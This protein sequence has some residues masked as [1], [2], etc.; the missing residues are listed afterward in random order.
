MKFD[1]GPFVERILARNEEE[2]IAIRARAER[3]LQ[4][5]GILAER[6]LQA[7]PDVKAVILFGSLA[8][9]GPKRLEFDIDIALDGGDPYKAM[10]IT[11]DSAF[12]VDVVSLRLLPAHVRE[13]IAAK[14]VLLATRP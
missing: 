1:P 2:R 9:S 4:E 13:R 8:E 3:A 6:I 5:A 14:G 11:E 7:D 12:D 10:D